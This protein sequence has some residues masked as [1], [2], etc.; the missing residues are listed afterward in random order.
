MRGELAWRVI[1]PQV[2]DIEVFEGKKNVS[3]ALL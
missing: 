2:G 3:L 1:S